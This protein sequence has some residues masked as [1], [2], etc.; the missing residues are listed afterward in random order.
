MSWM[1]VLKLIAAFGGLCVVLFGVLGVAVCL[2][3]R[4]W[5]SW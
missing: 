3:D 5:D 4:W 2:M 1:D